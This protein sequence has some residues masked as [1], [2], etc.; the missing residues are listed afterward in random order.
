MKTEEGNLIVSFRVL[1]SKLCRCYER[2]FV[3]FTEAAHD[4]YK[5]YYNI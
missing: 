2:K 4:L 5:Y 3:E 1:S